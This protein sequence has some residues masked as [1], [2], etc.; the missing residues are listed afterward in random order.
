MRNPKMLGLIVGS[1]LVFACTG[2]NEEVAEGPALGSGSSPLAEGTVSGVSFSPAEQ[3]AV[4]DLVNQ[5]EVEVL[6]K[7]VGIRINAVNNIVAA[8]PIL[9]LGQL[10]AVP[11]VGP[12]ALR[13]LK[14]YLPTWTGEAARDARLL[15]FVNHPSVTYDELNNIRYVGPLHAQGIIEYRQLSA[16]SNLDELLTA[17][18]SAGAN[19]LA[20]HQV[21]SIRN[22]VESWVPPAGADPVHEPGTWNGVVFSGFEVGVVLDIVNNASFEI[23][24]DEVRLDSRAATNIVG[25]RPI[26]SMDALDA[27]P[28]VATQAFQRLKAFVPNW[29]PDA[30]AEPN[31]PTPEPGEVLEV[32][33]VA[34]TPAEAAAVIDMAN[35]AP[36]DLL[37]NEVRLD[38]R[39]A[40]NIV[41][42]RPIADLVALDA[43]PYVAFTALTR[44]KEFIPQWEIISPTTPPVTG[45]TYNGV[46]FTAEEETVALEIANLASPA[47]LTEGGVTASPRNLIVGNR[48]WNEL[49][50]VAAFSGIGPATMNAIKNMVPDWQGPE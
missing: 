40:N 34:F 48:P 31:E 16:I 26:A 47:Q 46:E 13:A 10:D 22:Y 21:Q 20:D 36:H 18:A 43:I 4:L 39:A 41:A 2:Q 27:I 35:R 15:E 8:R 44:M 23:L 1:A 37:D 38:V 7:D 28:Y 19:P 49:A 12:A 6:N 3:A 32:S 45:G 17:S 14:D 42:A 30:P 5:A 9:T 11:Y 50:A 33:G 24:N 25:R 29:T